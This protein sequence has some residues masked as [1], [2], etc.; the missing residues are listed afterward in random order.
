MFNSITM[1]QHQQRLVEKR[2]ETDLMSKYRVRANSNDNYHDN[3]HTDILEN[4]HMLI[5]ESNN[6]V[7][8]FYKIV[9]N[10]IGYKI[11]RAL[12]EK[13]GLAM[14]KKDK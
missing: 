8:Q 14:V 3:N 11:T 1:T 10:K 5:I 12:N 9:F 7:F 4:T 2:S 6:T 13:E